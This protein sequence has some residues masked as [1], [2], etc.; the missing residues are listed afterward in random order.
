[1]KKKRKIIQT[2]R[3]PRRARGRSTMF[4]LLRRGALPAFRAPLRSIVQ[5]QLHGASTVVAR[6]ALCTNT[7]VLHYTDDYI[8]G[9]L[10]STKT[11]AIVGA[12]A[13]WRRPSYFA[14]KYL[15]SKG[16]RCIPINPKA[17]KQGE[18]ILGEQVY[19]SIGEARAGALEGGTFDMVDVFRGSEAAGAVA[20][21]AIAEGSRVLWMQLG[22][23]NDA[24]A[25][26]AVAAGLQ[27]VMNRCPKIE[28]S[29]LFQE[30]G[31][32]GGNTGVITS[33]RTP[34][35]IATAGRAGSEPGSP[36]GFDSRSAGFETLAI[37]A[38]GQPEPTSGSRRIPIFQNTSYVFDDVD[39]AASL[40]N[41]QVRSVRMRG[42]G[43]LVGTRL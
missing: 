10:T 28:F 39:H 31:W 30:L 34:A 33:K 4:S 11:I 22:V 1:M 9:L 26:R 16:Y 8:R 20:D 6:R 2:Y 18:P 7:D 35:G 36:A 42:L 41:L 32:H 37:H 43:V 21:E 14:M 19:A 15:Q 24:A 12:S 13:D 3:R 38:G 40:F 5:S 23:R 17:A 27:V 25:D 29:R